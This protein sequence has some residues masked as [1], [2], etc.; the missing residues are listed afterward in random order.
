MASNTNPEKKQ[1]NL[2]TLTYNDMTWIDITEPTEEATRYLAEHFHFNP[3]D[4]EDALSLRQISKV[5]TYPDYLFIV[6]HVPVYN[7][8]TRIAQRMQWSVFVGEKYVVTLRPGIF[9]PLDELFRQCEL[10]EDARKEYIGQGGG[11]LLYRILDRTI[12]AYFPVLNTILNLMEGIEDVVFNDEIEA[13]KE[14]SILRRDIITQRRIM[15]PTRALFVELEKRL[16]RFS[17]TNLVPFL[18]DLMDHMNK[19]TD[20][21]DE[22]REVIDVYKDADYILSG[23]RAN[24]IYRLIAILACIGLPFIIITGV[25]SMR[26]YLP[27][28]EDPGN[29]GVFFAIIG[30]AVA[31]AGLL[32]LFLKKKR[33][34]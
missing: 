11:Y 34:F 27:G 18:S 28:G 10:S 32:I 25:F 5:E 8:T 31:A 14:I 1:L 29:L 6:F 2:K 4:L 20:M 12:D 21:L 33:F 26:V 22:F 30:A 19:V 13:G 9:K 15:F 23:Y 17:T 7:K 3:L 24:R 16:G